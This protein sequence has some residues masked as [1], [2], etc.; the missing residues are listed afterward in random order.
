MSLRSLFRL[1]LEAAPHACA[2]MALVFAMGA[3]RVALSLA[4]EP[5]PVASVVVIAVQLLALLGVVASFARAA[6]ELAADV[7]DYG[8]EGGA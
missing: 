7:R 5:R 6:A 3:V 1:G 8:G 2:W 4:V